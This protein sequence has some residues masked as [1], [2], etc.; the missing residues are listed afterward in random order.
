MDSLPR[1]VLYIITKSNWGGAQAQAYTLAAHFQQ[2][3]ADVAV[4]L[5]GTGERGATTG[6]LADQLT[7]AGIRTIFLP[8]FARDV[9]I[10]AEVKALLQLIRILRAERPH[11]VHLHSSKAGGL[12]ALAARI[13]GVRRILFTS[14]GLAYDEDRN[15]FSRSLIWLATWVTFLLCHAVIVISQ[16][17]YA[18]ARQ[19]P[20]CKNKVHLI[21]NGT[22]AQ[23]LLTR[24]EARATLLPHTE[25]AGHVWI[26]TI[27]EFTRN[28]GLGYL[29]QAAALLKKRG[30]SFVL[31]LIGTEGEER[32]A[33]EK[34]IADEDLTNY[35]HLL[36]FVPHGAMYLPAFDIFALT[37]VKE[38]LPY[39]LLEAAAAHCAVVASNIPGVTDVVDKASGVLVPP[40]DVPAIANALESLIVDR[41]Q[42]LTLSE[43]LHNKV[44]MQFSL[45]KMFAQIAALYS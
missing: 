16:D 23:T 30:L 42:R 3:G 28:K 8:S 26:G 35:V 5:G 15:P 40:K 32:P 39:V 18:R 38:G 25:T 7:T 22:V 17:T 44:T 37:S 4:V 27:A 19:L 31:C 36:G 2:S 41:T 29:V 43:A 13:A 14:H 24:E 20:F 11:A 45:E 33:L 10:T 9:F 1:K 6:R 12:G 34:L 21:Y